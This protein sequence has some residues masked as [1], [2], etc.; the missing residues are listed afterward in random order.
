TMR[1]SSWLYGG[2]LCCCHR[3]GGNLGLIQSTR[4]LPSR[5]AVAHSELSLFVS[6]GNRSAYF[7]DAVFCSEFAWKHLQNLFL[8]LPTAL[9][10]LE[11]QRFCRFQGQRARVAVGDREFYRAGGA[12]KHFL[13]RLSIKANRILHVGFAGDPCRKQ[14]NIGRS[15]FCSSQVIHSHAG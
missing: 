15:R 5:A 13:G 2:S 4:N 10:A 14:F 8:E 3:R 9:Q 7:I 1:S 11:L 12:G 6:Q